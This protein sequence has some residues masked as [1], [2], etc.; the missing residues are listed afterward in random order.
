[1]PQIQKKYIGGIDHSQMGS[2]WIGCRENLQETMV[3]HVF[4]IKYSGFS[5]K[6]SPLNR[7][8]DTSIVILVTITILIILRIILDYFD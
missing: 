7:S 2:H 1:M 4:T 5:C 8:N 6:R 3:F